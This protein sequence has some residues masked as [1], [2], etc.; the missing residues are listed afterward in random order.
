M[1]DKAVDAAVVC[2]E[3]DNPLYLEIT[4]YAYMMLD[5][6]TY[7]VVGTETSE[8]YNLYAYYAYVSGLLEEA[9]D[10]V[11]YANIK[12]VVEGLMKYSV[13]AKAYKAAVEA[14]PAV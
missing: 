4:M 14:A 13:S 8:S 10:S 3:E 2:D 5:D 11:E 1:G 7:T 6:V 12:A 9:P